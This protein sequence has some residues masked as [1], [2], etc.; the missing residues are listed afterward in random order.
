[1]DATNVST[2]ETIEQRFPEEWGADVTVTAGGETYERTVST[3]LGEPE[4]PMSAAESRAKTEGLLAG[5]SI[6]PERLTTAVDSIAGAPQERLRR[7]RRQRRRWARSRRWSARQPSENGGPNRG[8]TRRRRRQAFRR[9][10]GGR[11]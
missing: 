3:P 2:D 11:C 5:T 9:S 10:P 1:M 6:D 4:T 7:S 8:A